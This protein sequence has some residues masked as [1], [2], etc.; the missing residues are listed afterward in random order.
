MAVFYKN[1]DTVR[2][3]ITPEKNAEVADTK[4]KLAELKVAIQWETDIAKRKELERKLSRMEKFD[5]L[6]EG[7]D[8]KDEKTKEDVQKILK[9]KN[10][11]TYSNSDLLTLRKKNIDIASLTLVNKENPDTAV[12]SNE[13]KSGDSFTVN[14]GSNASLRDR[15]G[16]GDILPPTVKNI[17]IN[18]VECERKNTP[19]PGYYD[20]KWEYQKILDGYTIDIVT[21]GNGTDED[22]KANEKRWKNERVNDMIDINGGNPLADTEDDRSLFSDVVQETKE[23]EVLRKS[24]EK[25][26]LWFERIVPWSEE[27]KVLFRNACKFAGINEDWASSN[28]IYKILQNESG[29]YVGRLNYTL[30]NMGLEEFKWIALSWDRVPARSSASG[31]GQLLLSNV[32]KYY[33][34][35]RKGIGNPLDEAVGMIK[36]IQD[37][38]WDPQTALS[39]YWKVWD[40]THASTWKTLSK[41]FKEGY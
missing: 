20:A 4:S 19:R 37:R 40:Y 23:R 13:L 41:T 6:Q 10:T 8:I 11:E 15:T 21:T 30:G 28:A 25:Q 9:W 27:C 33:P 3:P 32:D 14:F 17:R 22:N 29:G 1:I 34:S 36:Y 39:V 24:Y 16:A 5:R 2:S 35:W 26:I 12:K 31:L 18:G 7:T 38:Y